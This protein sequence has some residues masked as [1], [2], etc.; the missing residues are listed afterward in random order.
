MSIPLNT[1]YS[2]FETGDFPTQDQFQASWSSFWHKDES[3]PTGKIEGLDQQ[4]QNKTDKKIFEQH[5]ANPDSHADYLAKKDATNLTERN[6]HSWRGALGVGQLPDNI[7][8]VDNG[9]QT[10]STYTK[11]QSDTRFMIWDD[12]VNGDEKILAEKIEAL[13]ITTLIQSVETTIAEFAGNSNAYQFEDNDFIA[14][15]DNNGHFSLYMFKGGEKTNTANYLPTGL[16]NV[17]IGMVEGLQNVL[18]TKMDK[19]TAS[20]NYIASLLNGTVTWKAVNPA[21]NYLMYWNGTDFKESGVFHS[22]GKLGIGLTTPAEQLHLTGRV[23]SMGYILEENN[24]TVNNQITAFN[25]NLLFTNSVGIKKT[26]L[27]NEDLPSEFL[28]LPAKLTK[29]QKEQFGIDWNNQYSNGNLNVY[30]LT[31]TVIKN[32]HI[33][34]Y[35]VLQGLNLNVNPAFTSIKFIPVGNAIGTGEIECLG[36]QTFANGLSMIVSVY[37]DSLQPGNSYNLVIRTT[38]PTIQVHR[39]TGSINV[40]DT[41]NNIDISGLKWE[42]KS[43]TPE[44]E[45]NIFNINGGLF[46]YNS[47]PNN[48]AY[49]YEP[50]VIVASA[51]SDVVFEAN[52]NFYLEMN[53]ALSTV[54][55]STVSDAYDFYGYLGLIQKSIP[56]ALADNSFLRVIGSSFRSGGYESVLVWNNISSLATK[57][58]PGAAVI[59]ANIIIMRQ[60]NVYTQFVTVGSTSV[61]QSITST[62]EAVSLSLVTSNSSRQKTINGSVVQA[63]TF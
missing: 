22:A 56:L 59:N 4:L 24:E 3:I 23:R 15:P 37:G 55:P 11:R 53:M 61:I 44:Q 21:S 28:K 9:D 51:K 52:T 19:P 5:L 40:V 20:G 29:A 31:P 43:Y 18:N 41:I 57:I 26:I 6:I 33:V 17:T 58:E 54:G 2:Y 39:T 10:G 63:F 49:V 34:R 27:T 50:N 60:G 1:I 46:K 32:D 30:G 62:T 35:F 38:N 16:S 12:F 42:T 45:G 47:S 25:R 36:F 13:G 8:T 48:K 14:I 7:A